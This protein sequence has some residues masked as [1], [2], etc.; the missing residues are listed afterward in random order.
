MSEKRIVALGD[1]D[2]VHLGHKE[3]LRHL[4]E[5][6]AS[7]QAEPVVL[8]FDRNT[9]GRKRITAPMVR[10]YY[11]RRYGIEEIRIL[12][13]DEWKDVSAEDFAEGFLKNE[14]HAVG[15]ICGEDLHFGKDRLG[16]EFTLIGKGIA[17]RKIKDQLMNDLRISSSAIRADLEQGNLLAAEAKMGHPFTLMGEVTH[18][19]GLARQHGCPTANLPLAKEQLL[20]PF[21]VY[22]AW[23]WAEDRC[24]PAAANLGVRPTLEKEGEANLEAHL[25]EEAPDLYGKTI[26]VELKSYIRREMRFES[27]EALFEQIKRDGEICKAR[28]EK[29]K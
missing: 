12:P 18:G 8:S 9:K 24:Y 17:V 21:G 28:L 23:V 15:L 22:A 27:E 11:L 2:G 13:F 25:L 1:F 19:K 6:A 20:L 4:S 3:L 14:L 5:W 7:L 26:R 16:N 29:S 10:D